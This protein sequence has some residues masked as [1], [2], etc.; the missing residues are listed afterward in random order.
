[1]AYVTGASSF[2]LWEKS[3]ENSIKLFHRPK[4]VSIAPWFVQTS[5]KVRA[6]LNALI[7]QYASG[8]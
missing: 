4:S 1:M 3:W 5:Y 7:A 6:M 8:H 2:D